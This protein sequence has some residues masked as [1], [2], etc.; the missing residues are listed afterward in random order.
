VKIM[1][2]AIKLQ[3]GGG[4]TYISVYDGKVAAPEFT[5][6]K[7][8]KRYLL[9]LANAGTDQYSILQAVTISALTNASYEYL[10]APSV[11][12]PGSTCCGYSSSIIIPSNSTVRL[13]RNFQH[14]G[15]VNLYIIK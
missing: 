4:N 3:K 8:N 1:G 15:Y 2:Y 5:D 12:R 7:I 6:L 13:T 10:S 9:T 14:N 11:Y